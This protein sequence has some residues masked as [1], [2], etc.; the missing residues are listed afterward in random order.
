MDLRQV[1]KAKA[2][3]D[4]NLELNPNNS[5]KNWQKSRFYKDA[6]DLDRI[7]AALRKT[8]LPE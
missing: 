7:L 8:G 3:A 4:E 2:L 5:L 1:E 6:A